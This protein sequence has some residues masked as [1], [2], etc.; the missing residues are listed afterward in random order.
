[1]QVMMNVGVH[2]VCIGKDC[3]VV[4]SDFTKMSKY[5]IEEE[6][7]DETE[8]NVGS[9][10]GYYRDILRK[11]MLLNFMGIDFYGKGYRREGQLWKKDD[12]NLGFNWIFCWKWLQ[13]WWSFAE[14]LVRMLSDLFR[15]INFF[16]WQGYFW[17]FCWQPWMLVLFLRNYVQ[18]RWPKSVSKSHTLGSGIDLRNQGHKGYIG[19]YV[20]RILFLVWNWQQGQYWNFNC[21]RLWKNWWMLKN[22]RKQMRMRRDF[23]ANVQ[24]QVWVESQKRWTKRCF[25]NQKKIKACNMEVSFMGAFIRW[26]KKGGKCL[27]ALFYWWFGWDRFGKKISLFFCKVS[28]KQWLMRPIQWIFCNFG[29]I[30]K[31]DWFKKHLGFDDCFYTLKMGLIGCWIYKPDFF[32]KKFCFFLNN[33]LCNYG[34]NYIFNGIGCWESQQGINGY[35]LIRGINGSEIT[36]WD[37]FGKEFCLGSSKFLCNFGPKYVVFG[38]G[39][40]KSQ[41]GIDGLNCNQILEFLFQILKKGIDGFKSGSILRRFS[42]RFYCFMQHSNVGCF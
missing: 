41:Q 39:S 13:I 29:S 4:L 21:C 32:C 31:K 1:M 16:K 28:P 33:F 10:K 22:V 14:F 6:V 12:E 20:E 3:N 34:P 38:F 35:I 18:N 9:I 17:Y 15:A 40:W 5:D 26:S 11:N 24:M 27:I 23:K 42:K 36:V 2:I 8:I 7:W 25:K 19:I 30:L 37:Q